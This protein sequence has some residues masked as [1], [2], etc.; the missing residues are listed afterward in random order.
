MKKKIIW[1]TFSDGGN[2]LISYNATYSNTIINNGMASNNSIYFNGVIDVNGTQTK[3]DIIEGMK[4]DVCNSFK[5]DPIECL[6]L[7]NAF[8]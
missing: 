6:F 7:G 1:L 5:F 2:N 4:N 3:D 8:L